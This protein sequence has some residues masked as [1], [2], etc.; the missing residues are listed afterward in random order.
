MSSVA[1]LLEGS[2]SRINEYDLVVII[3]TWNVKEL[4]VNCLRSVLVAGSKLSVH[5]VVVDNAS[6]DGTG[7]MMKAQFPDIEFLYNQ[8]NLGFAS[9]NNIALRKYGFQA[10]YCLLLN[11][12]TVVPADVFVA[13]LDFMERHPDAGMAGCKVVK[14]DGVLDWPCKRS[15]IVPSVLFYKAVGLDRLFPKSP[16]FGR[17]HLTYLDENET[18]EVDA[19]VGAFMLIR[20]QCLLQIGELDSSIFMYGEDLEWC[21]RAKRAGWKVYYVPTTS[22][23]HHKGKSSAK[24]SYHMIGHWYRG[25]WKVYEKQI[26]P[27]YA[28]PINVMVWLGFHVMCGASL[29]TNLLRREKRVPSRR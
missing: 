12:D 13:M 6:S 18:H 17:Y 16:R 24:R 23:V 7:E 22:I 5:V 11:P 28:W 9:A 2:A 21:Y 20:Q 27:D 3:V 4:L 25:A 15:R 26:A 14:E 19:I 10:K 8:T 29:F 1:A